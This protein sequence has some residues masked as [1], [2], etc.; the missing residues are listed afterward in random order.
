MVVVSVVVDVFVVET[1]VVFGVDGTLFSS[2]LVFF[3]ASLGVP[4]LFEVAL[5]SLLPFKITGVGLD[6]F[7]PLFNGCFPS[8][9]QQQQHH[10]Y[11][12]FTYY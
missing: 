9:H 7:A 8:H 3:S 1:S 6:F 2:V 5:L 10:N 4:M 12:R 11:L